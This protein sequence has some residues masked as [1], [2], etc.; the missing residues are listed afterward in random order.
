MI[1]C[2]RVIHIRKWVLTWCNRKVAS[3]GAI[4]KHGFRISVYQ[5]GAVPPN[6]VAL[7]LIEPSYCPCWE[8]V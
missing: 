6:K 2:L 8:G 7:N 5:G 4:I 3:E 1:R